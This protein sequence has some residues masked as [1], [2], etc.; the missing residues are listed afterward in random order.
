MQTIADCK[1][2]HHHRKVALFLI[3]LF[4]SQGLLLYETIARLRTYFLSS[5]LKAQQ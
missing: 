5:I 3:Y 2:I 1:V 4:L